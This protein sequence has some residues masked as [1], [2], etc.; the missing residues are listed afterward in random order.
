[1][2]N[3]YGTKIDFEKRNLINKKIRLLKDMS[4]T[5]D[6]ARKIVFQNAKLSKTI[7]WN[8]LKSDQMSSYPVLR[9]MMAEADTKALDSPWQFSNILT[10][11]LYWIKTKIGELSQEREEMFEDKSKKKGLQS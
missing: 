5:I 9:D 11:V 6:K 1:M 10:D 4:V 3:W 2:N 8:L 7:N